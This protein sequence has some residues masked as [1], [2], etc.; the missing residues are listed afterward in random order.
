MMIEPASAP[1]PLE[2]LPWDTEHFGFEVGRV[3]PARPTQ[4]ELARAVEA[5]RASGIACLYLGCPVDAL[6]SV[7]WAARAGFRLVDLRV[8]LEREAAPVSAVAARLA[9]PAEI[10]G[11]VALARTTFGQ[12]RFFADGQFPPRRVEDLYERWL[13]RDLASEG[14]AVVVELLDGTVAGFASGRVEETGIGRIGLV[15]VASFARGRGVGRR[16]V[17]GLSGELARRGAQQLSVV[18]QA[19]NLSALRLYEG[20]GFQTASTSITLHWWSNENPV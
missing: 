4:K 19:Q 13:R 2:P 11:A 15:A 16:I 8:T 10:P 9:S 14:G 18:T 12:S 7:T 6:Q 5:A 1:S 3:V 17:E 20:L